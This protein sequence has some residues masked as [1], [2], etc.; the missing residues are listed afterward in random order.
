MS[1]T[2]PETV[3]SNASSPTDE[4]DFPS[5][6]RGTAFWYSV[7][8][9]GYGTFYALNNASL[10]LFLQNMH[11]SNVL[12]GLMGSSHSIEGAVIQPVVG[13]FS[14]RLRTRIGRRRPFM[15]GFIPLSAL[16]L[17]LT[18]AASHLP[19][20]IRLP[21]VVLAIFL[22]TVLFN[23][24]QDPYQA[25]LPDVFP[26]EQRGRVTGIWT[27]FGVTGQAML[28]LLPMPLEAKFGLVA[29]LILLTTALTCWRVRE[30][31]LPPEPKKQSHFAELAGAASGLGTLRQARCCLLG[32]FFSGV[33][34]GAVL[35]FLTVF[36]KKITGCSDHQAEQMFLVLMAATALGVLPS[37]WLTDRIG[38]KRVLMSGL[39]VIGFAALNGLWVRTLPQVACVL[40]V[41]GLGNAMQS[42]STYPLLCRL[43][44]REEV[45]F[46]TG[47]SSTALSIATPMTAVVT[48]LLVDR[49]GYRWIFGVCGISMALALLVL[50]LLN[51]LSAPEEIAVRD[52][53]EGRSMTLPEIA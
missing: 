43:V 30:P 33:G 25:L 52:R 41:A 23:I 38:P 15:I 17:L 40:F 18:P 13:A 42:A 7:A 35:P 24:A 51:M 47:L 12:I 34:I 26:E 44:P 37:G 20:G 49:G 53:A 28:V 5:P 22:F 21:A 9:F 27:F 1:V 36:V 10:T 46:Y 48:G 50:T 2:P 14:D 16:F 31:L 29:V 6:P 3:L 32:L 4:G 45:G 39:G 19:L 8:S 11:A